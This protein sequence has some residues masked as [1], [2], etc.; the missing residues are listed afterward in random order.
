MIV[1]YNWLKEFVDCNLAP[2]ELAHRLTMAGL[3]V[4]AMELIGVGLDTVIVARLVSVDPHPEADRLTVCQVETGS[5][6]VQVICGAKNHRS[7]DL[8]ALAQVGSVLP[9]DFKIKRSKIRGLESQGMLCS[10]KELGLAEESV[11]IM[12]LP[13]GL[14]L[15][16]P[17]FEALGLKDVRFELGLTPNRADC[18]SIVGVA[19]EVAAMTGSALRLP[20]A[21]VAENG[22]EIERQTSVTIEEPELCPRY[23]ARLIRNV[24][25]GPSPEW[26]VRRLESVGQRSINNVVDVTNYVLLELGHPL[27]AF[28]FR[29]L[30]GGRIVVKRAAGG[31]LFTTLDSQQRP[32]ESTDLTICD[33]EGP[34]ALAGIMG[35]ENSE[36]QTDTV[37]ILL[38]SAYFH[39]G[40]IRRTSK[41]LG[42][43]T[44]SSHR[45]ER[46]AD[47]NMVPVALDRAAALIAEV[48]GGTVAKGAIDNYPKPM[49]ARRIEL[50]VHQTNRI[51]GLVLT[52]A[53]IRGLLAAIGLE[54][55]TGQED[56]ADVLCVNLP[57]FRPDLE[58]EIDLIEEVARLNGYDRIPVSLPES[59]IACQMPPVHVERIGRARNAMVAAGF[60]EVINYSFV[61][62]DAW[63]R[64]RLPLDDPRRQTVAIL[65]P[66]NEEQ[67]VMRTSLVPSL[68][69]TAARNLAYRSRDLRLFELRPV[70][71][72]APDQ[73]LPRE[74]QHLVAAICGRRAP[75]G[76]GQPDDAVDFFDLK[77]TVEDLFRQFRV[78]E[79]AWDPASSEPFMHPG[80]SCS[81][82]A[83]SVPV[84]IIG[85]VHP[86]VLSRYQI[87]SPLYLVDLD[88]DAVFSKTGVFPGIRPLSRF[89]DVCRDSALLLAEDVTAGQLLQAIDRVKPR[90]VEDVL[91]FDVYRGAG[92]P[93]GQKS[94][95]I[96]VRYRSP[97][98]TLTDEEIQSAHGRIV[99]ALEREFAAKIR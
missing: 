14:P 27:H 75:E 78:T 50:S 91:L 65:N 42:I 85:E 94:V 35:G 37:D 47:I 43:H 81:I 64:I 72:H 15:G 26:M 16:I 90:F 8:V 52:P 99:K 25:I 66:L 24:T 74:R 19:R 96:R 45:F 71:L 13:A 95:A 5:G 55:E 46:G 59:R 73:E 21:V 88:L 23:A 53:V 82:K 44:E 3:E 40:A 28:D 29:L 9:G 57:T 34:V 92:V 32:L 36:I 63:D 84:G 48:A 80:K 4:D 79:V 2:E 33:G 60:S 70:F 56:N 18:L 76:W 12:I 58:R 98:K 51:L 31:A 97:E 68:L 49:A 17:V 87:D 61:A 11:G 41:R 67:S 86:E 30:R 77:G 6:R 89:P 10:E 69:E 20:P 22:E 38:E 93:A 39:P 1:T 62:P 83:G 54:S 7:G